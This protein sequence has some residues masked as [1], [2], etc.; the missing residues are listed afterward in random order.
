M[1]TL[2]STCVLVL[3]TS[4]VRGQHANL[5]VLQ[6]SGPRALVPRSTVSFTTVIRNSG[7]ATTGKKTDAAL[8]LS[9]NTILTHSD[10]LLRQWVT[11]TLAKG[12]TH[13]IINR[14][15]LP[16]DLPA[17]SHYVG[18][19]ADPWDRLRELDETDNTATY[20]VFAQG[21]PDL[22]IKAFQAP[23]LLY[24]GRQ[25]SLVVDF[26]NEGGVV[27]RD[28]DVGFYLSRDAQ[29]D[30]SDLLIGSFGPLS[31]GAG[32]RHRSVRSIS[33]GPDQPVG[34][35]FLIAYL[36]HRRALS[37]L[38]TGNNV[39]ARAVRIGHRG[40]LDPFGARC[41]GS[42]GRLPQHSVKVLN[43]NQP[44][45]GALL[46][47]EVWQGPSNSFGLFAI[48][49]SRERWGALRL[50][51]VFGNCALSVSLDVSMPVGM[52]HTG[53]ARRR[54]AIPRVLGLVGA[55]V[56]TQFLCL[57]PKANA[58]GIVPTNAWTVEIGWD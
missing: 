46:E 20:R 10:R 9:T 27:A 16:K 50:P 45:P 47:H 17:G 31:L 49:A 29:F 5:D 25:A 15:S 38:L 44:E 3:L 40:R 18:V 37:E 58:L 28:F 51:L 30:R 7:Q 12:L 6:I 24:R 4:L 56:H 33:L 53:Y 54:L 13:K 21:K 41:R 22:V 42:D 14:V 34:N 11:P 2:I 26:V 43:G 52:D 8:Y 19:W 1:Q 48:G 36:D 39:V 35:Y 57:D 55:R 23:S 32:R